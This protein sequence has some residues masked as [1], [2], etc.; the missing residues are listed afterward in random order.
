MKRIRI[1]DLRHSFGSIWAQRLPLSVLKAMLGH[2]SV[3][4]TEQY[5]H[6][7]GEVFRLTLTEA[8]RNIAGQED[9]NA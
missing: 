1:H 5:I 8:L 9:E 7:T 4:T 3:R 2:A 6:T